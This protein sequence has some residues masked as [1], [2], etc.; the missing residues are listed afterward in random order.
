MYPSAVPFMFVI[1]SYI[2]FSWQ[3]SDKAS[4]DSAAHLSELDSRVGQQSWQRLL[5][6]WLISLDAVTVIIYGC[7]CWLQVKMAG[8]I[9]NCCETEVTLDM[10][11]LQFVLSTKFIKSDM[12]ITFR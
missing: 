4:I 2:V 11:F 10:G 3:F 12:F 8:M 6:S 7:R 1:Y 5:R 9:S